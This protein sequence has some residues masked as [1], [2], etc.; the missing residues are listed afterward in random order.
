VVTDVEAN[1]GI[2]CSLKANGETVWSWSTKEKFHFTA[3]FVISAPGLLEVDPPGYTQYVF[4][5]GYLTDDH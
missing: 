1:Y 5:R 3:G 4:L 2:S